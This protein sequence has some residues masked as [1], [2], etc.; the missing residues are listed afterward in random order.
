MTF[1]PAELNLIWTAVVNSRAMTGESQT[2]SQTIA[3]VDP[4]HYF[5]T[6]T[7]SFSQ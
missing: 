4:L 2:Q 3:S 5:A 6:N 1:S 7:D